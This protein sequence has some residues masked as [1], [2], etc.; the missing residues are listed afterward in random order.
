MS[1]MADKIL[2]GIFAV[3]KP[4]GSTTSSVV[5]KIKAIVVKHNQQVDCEISKSDNSWKKLKVGHGGTLDK[6]AEGIIVLGIGCDCKRL[7]NYLRN[8]TKEYRVVAE[9]GAS[10]DTYDATGSITATKP[11]CHVTK[12]IVEQCISTKFNGKILQRPPLYSALKLNGERL[13][14]LVRRGVHVP[15]PS[16]REIIIKS[17]NINSFLPP[18]ITFTVT[19]T[20]GTYIRSLI[21]DLGMELGTCSHVKHLIRTRDGSFAIDQALREEDWSVGGLLKVIADS[22]KFSYNASV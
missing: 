1:K 9:L 22:K 14:D 19:C 17:F 12:G 7:T 18:D 21:H 15:Q 2:R 13:S 20:S 5:N 16:P 4:P 11:Y 6:P 10:T 8:T 3:Y